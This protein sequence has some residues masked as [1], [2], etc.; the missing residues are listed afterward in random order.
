MSNQIRE[1]VIVMIKL[2]NYYGSAM[3]QRAYVRLKELS[4]NVL[5]RHTRAFNE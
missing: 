3:C 5:S 2:A 4:K 1:F